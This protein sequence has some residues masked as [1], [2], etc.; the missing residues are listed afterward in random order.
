MP[1][2][3]GSNGDPSPYEDALNEVFAETE[4]AERLADAARK[5]DDDPRTIAKAER[6]LEKV[7]DAESDARRAKLLRRAL[8]ID[9]GCVD[10]L[11]LVARSFEDSTDAVLLLD[12]AVEVGARRLGEPMFETGLGKFWGIY[13]TRPYMRALLA[14]AEA[15]LDSMDF[16]KAFEFYRRLIELSE[17]DNLGVRN[18]LVGALL[19]A[20]RLED[21]RQLAFDRFGDEASP[22]MLWARTL[23]LFLERDFDAAAVALERARAAN[24]HVQEFLAGEFELSDEPPALYQVGSI[25]EA[26][27][28]ARDL[29][30]AWRLH[31]LALLWLEVGGKPGDDRY[32]GGYSDPELQA[33]LDDW[34]DEDDFDEDD[35]EDEGP[36]LLN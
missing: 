9:P 8:E 6:T 23:I 32:F 11:T 28:V 1:R 20:D 15:E 33:V 25:E 27:I 36:Y 14:L 22:L 29:T 24:E 21:A 19:Y 18:T 31:P 26:E 10:A 30:P 7:Y 16:G 5:A 3:N 35:D 12:A 2:S 4:E 34:D 17:D 13:E